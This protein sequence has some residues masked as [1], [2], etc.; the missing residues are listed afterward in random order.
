M[1]NCTVKLRACAIITAALCLMLFSA[2]L[3]AEYGVVYRTDT[4]N[5]RSQGSSNSQW[6]GAYTRGT[7]VEITGS[8]NNFYRVRTPDNKTGYMSKNYIDPA[9]DENDFVW[10]VLVTNQNGGAFLNF[11][12]QPNYNSQVLGIFY[13]GVPL[14]V[15]NQSNGWYFVEIN[16]R[17]GY[18]R[19]EFVTDW[20]RRNAGSSIVATIKTPNNTAINLRNGPGLDYSTAM[21]FSGDRYVSVITKG[22]G[23]WFVS[24]DGYTGF[25]SSDFLT[26]GLCAARD[27][28]AQSTSGTA[29]AVVSNPRS[30]Q[31]LNLRQFAST[32]AYVLDS[33][34][35]GDRLWVNEQGTEWCSVTDQSTGLTGY[36]MTRYITLHNLPSTPTKRVYH[37]NG[38]YVNLR[39]SADMNVGNVLTRVPSGSSVTIVTP[40]PDWCQVRYGGATGY[41][42]S[43]FLQ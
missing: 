23:W 40:G 6:L 2:A 33:L 36:V 18:V 29:Y 3:A 25:M 35:N 41:M 8:Q 38:T 7:W 22:N 42:L 26:E 4:L 28:A 13:S 19:S 1:K 14:R 39:S 5:L 20:G 34:Y 9:I 16:G 37:P 17:A 31:A 21:Q 10:T 32:G 30:S 27:L 11:R 43:Y 24:I 12:A 15:L